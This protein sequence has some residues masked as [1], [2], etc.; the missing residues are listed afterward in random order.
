MNSL[1][2]YLR[3]A[4]ALLLG[5][6]CVVCGCFLPGAGVC[7]K[8]L[9]Q[10]PYINIK[11]AAGN[12]IERL[13]WGAVPVERASAMLTYH[14]GN[15]MEGLIHAIKYHNR[16]DLAVEMGRHMAQELL[17]TDFF[18]GIDYLQP[19]PLHPSRQRERGYNQSERLARGISQLTGLPVANFVS[20]TVHNA[21][22]TQL[23]H[24]ER[25]K[26]V[27]GIFA[28][29]TTELLCHRPRHILI[30]DDVITTGST[31]ISCAQAI[32]G[33][34]GTSEPVLPDIR[35]SFLSLC[36][37]GRFHQG[38]LSCQDLGLADLSI[39]NAEFRERQ[40]STL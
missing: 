34:D 13:F 9:L 29:V 18:D 1:A 3:T 8:C 5:E 10:L 40:I 28:P 21:S 19:V 6:R 17:H 16:S 11:G 36:F 31:A 37:A 15:D 24:E 38:R 39:N 20:R 23:L 4:L 14:P 32:T 12:P 30:I 27:E 25:R 7:P 22:Q 2:T 33:G 35:V 26:N